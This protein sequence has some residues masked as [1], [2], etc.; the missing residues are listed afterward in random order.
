MTSATLERLYDTPALTT[1]D[2]LMARTTE[3]ARLVNRIRVASGAWSE[4][5]DAERRGLAD[6]LG[7]AVWR[8]NP[9]D[10]LRHRTAREEL[11]MRAL[12][13]DMVLVL[14]VLASAVDVTARR[15]GRVVRHG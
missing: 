13:L 1:P 3:K 2:A 6:R 12:L 14:A 15:L 4:L 7:F 9:A 5:S 8:L 10:T 11:R